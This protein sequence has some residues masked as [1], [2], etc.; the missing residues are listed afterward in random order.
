[1]S[2]DEPPL[3]APNHLKAIMNYSH[4]YELQPLCVCVCVCVCSHREGRRTTYIQTVDTYTIKIITHTQMEGILNHSI[5]NHIK[6]YSDSLYL[7][8]QLEKG[9]SL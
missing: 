2:E 6:S 7:F 8:S 4:N 3:L 1:M 5:L 9:T